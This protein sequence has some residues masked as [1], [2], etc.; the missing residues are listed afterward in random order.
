MVCDVPDVGFRAEGKDRVE[1][2]RSYFGPY[3]CHT[4]CSYTPVIMDAINAYFWTFCPRSLETVA[5]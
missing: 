2:R 4:E 3:I 1:F 5:G